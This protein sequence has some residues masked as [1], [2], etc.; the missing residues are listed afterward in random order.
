MSYNS[1]YKSN[2]GGPLYIVT[3]VLAGLV[4]LT[5]IFTL[6]T[7]FSMF[8]NL[9]Y[10]GD[11]QGFIFVLGTL[12]LGE[13]GLLLAFSIAVFARASN[14]VLGNIMIATGIATFADVFIRVCMAGLDLGIHFWITIGLLIAYEICLGVIIKS[15]VDVIRSRWFVPGILTSVSVAYTIVFQGEELRYTLAFI[16]DINVFMTSLLKPIVTV[17]FSFCVMKWAANRTIRAYTDPAPVHNTSLFATTQNSSSVYSGSPSV[18]SG[19]PPVSPY[20]AAVRRQAQSRPAVKVEHI[21]CPSCGRIMNKTD[22][23]CSNCG[24]D[25][26]AAPKTE[27]IKPVET[28]PVETTPDESVSFVFCHKCGMRVPSDCDFCFKCGSKILK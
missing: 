16:S 23:I 9:K 21:S 14:D 8:E 24:A 4:V 19:N 22:R 3:A 17:A 11:Q 7:I 10:Y 15:S 13:L 26:Q 28:T 2:S 6:K 5:N 1:D 12:S 20:S 18:Y 27:E 25:L